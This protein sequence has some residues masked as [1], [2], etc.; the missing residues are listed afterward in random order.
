MG[1]RS[2]HHIIALDIGTDAIMNVT[3]SPFWRP[4]GEGLNEGGFSQCGAAKSSGGD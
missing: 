3:F 2:A 4:N 1:G